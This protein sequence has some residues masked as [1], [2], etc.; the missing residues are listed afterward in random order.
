MRILDRYVVRQLI[1]VWIWC[2][3]VFLFLSCLIDVVE[4]LDDILRY[5][6]K[7][8]VV[9]QYY[10]NFAPLVFVRACPIALLFAAAFVAT[11]LCRHQELLAMNASGTSVLRASVPFL[12]VGWLTSIGVFL[13]ND[14][15]VPPAAIRYEQ[16]Q[17]EAFRGNRSPQ[18][19]ENVAALDDRNR[20]YHARKLDV[21][22]HELQD[23][24]VLEHNAYNR[25]ITSLYASRA[26]WT[27]H[28]WLLLY[29]TICRLG[30][31]GTIQGEPEP[32]VERLVDYP[33][34]PDTFRQPE[35]RPETMRFGQ[36]RMLIARLRHN[37][38]IQV[39]SYT[40]ELWSKLT[41]PLMN[42]LV[43]LISFVGST[44]PQLRGNLR[45]LGVSLGLG[46]VYYLAVAM[47]GGIAKEW[48]LPV[49]LILIAPHAAAVWWCL[50]LARR[51]P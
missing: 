7:A 37:G 34:T 45:G 41:W 38:F 31:G 10:L 29:G 28:G 26:I 43:C 14:R 23:L 24:T 35:A 40:V 3:I 17:R 1:P 27:R 33:V 39:R 5:H 8:R 20:L 2:V 12:F 44:R 18:K 47:A 16:I 48:P 11:R 36:L 9:V 25:P 51:M 30:A 32:F 49:L 42:L 19:L 46:M 6:I 50:K 22:E 13:V 15:I 4:H 21:A